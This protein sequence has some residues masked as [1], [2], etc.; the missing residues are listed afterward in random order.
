[1]LRTPLGRTKIRHKHTGRFLIGSGLF[2]V[3][4][5]L[6]SQGGRIE[7]TSQEGHSTAFRLYLQA[8]NVL[9]RIPLSVAF[10]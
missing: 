8:A 9:A 6:Q 1:M 3:N 7:A 10:A 4:R 2:L 5:L